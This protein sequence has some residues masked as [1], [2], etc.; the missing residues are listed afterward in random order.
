[1]ARARNNAAP[2][3]AEKPVSKAR[4]KQLDIAAINAQVQSGDLSPEEGQAQIDE[5]NG[6]AR[7]VDEETGNVTV[8]D[9]NLTDS[10]PSE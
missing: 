5:L 10:L 9:A 2:K 1:M 6:I 8:V 3:P 4:Q 7:E